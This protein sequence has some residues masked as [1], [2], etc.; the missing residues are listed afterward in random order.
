M[1]VII[2]GLLV[3]IWVGRGKERFKEKE[4]VINV[5]VPERKLNYQMPDEMEKVNA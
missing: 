1:C 2:L 3:Y 5:V 4:Q